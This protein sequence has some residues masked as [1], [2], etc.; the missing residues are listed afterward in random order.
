[1]IFDPERVAESPGL[2]RFL[3]SLVILP[4]IIGSKKPLPARGAACRK[5]KRTQGVTGL[6][7]AVAGLSGL[8]SGITRL[9]AGVTDLAS[10]TISAA[11][12]V[13]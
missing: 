12:L 10:K 2:L 7:S 9:G 1:M 11:D 6:A 8:A 4:S 3:G 5:E 13:S